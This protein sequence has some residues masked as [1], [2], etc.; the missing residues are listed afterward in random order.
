MPLPAHVPGVAV[1]LA[2][3]CNVP[4]TDGGEAAVKQ[5]TDPLIVA[6]RA[7]DPILRDIT[8]RIENEV[9]SVESVARQKI[10]QARFSVYGTS[11]YPDATFTLR[12]SYGK[13]SGY[14][15]RGLEPAQSP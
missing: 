2:P 6:A 10:G 1:S 12:L 7:I 8:K 14:P 11:V 3:C 9:T 13:A 15:M 5:S 4:V